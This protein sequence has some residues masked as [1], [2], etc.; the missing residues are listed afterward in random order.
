MMKNSKIIL[1]CLIS[2]MLATAASAQWVPLTDRVTLSSL[3]GKSLIFGD[4]EISEFDI[5]GFSDG[6]ALAPNPDKMFVQGGKNSITGDCGLKFNFSWSAVSNQTVNATLSFKVSILPGYD[7]Y[8]KDVRMDLTGAGATGNGVVA[9]TE[10]VQ[11][12]GGNVIA[13]LSCSKQYG[14]GGAYL[15]DHAEFTPVREI[16]I[17][18]KDISVTSGT[19]IGSAHISEFYQY[20]SQI[21]EPATL[22]LLGTAGIWSFTR[23]KRRGTAF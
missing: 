16:W 21:P 2:I 13:S 14:D 8:I 9:A 11:N 15:V 1:S 4:K 20:Y 17:L 18:S 3:Q 19:G 22:V 7:G 23:K 10:N 6:G 5:F 12:A